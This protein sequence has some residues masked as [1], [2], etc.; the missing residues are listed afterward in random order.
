MKYGGS[1]FDPALDEERLNE[2]TIRVYRLM[3][4]EEWRTL[5]E[6]SSVTEDPEASIS[7]R[8]RDLR[9]P[10]FGGFDR[11]DQ[12]QLEEARANARLI[13]AAPDLLEALQWYESKAKQMGR[14]AINKDSKLMLALMKEIAVEYGAQARAAIAKATGDQP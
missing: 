7:A 6:I 12:A 5:S 9:K 8:L 3:I 11:G 10:D 1:T 14:A 13:A 2:Q 4:D